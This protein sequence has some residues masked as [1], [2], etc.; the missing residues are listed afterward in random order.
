MRYFFPPGC[1]S[2]NDE[3]S[4]INPD[5]RI[6]GRDFDSSWTNSPASSLSARALERQEINWTD[7]YPRKLW[8]GLPRVLAIAGNLE[9]VLTLSTSLQAVLLQFRCLEMFAAASRGLARDIDR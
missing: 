2:I 6:R 3:T 7:R 5:I 1:L 9:C 8:V 4:W